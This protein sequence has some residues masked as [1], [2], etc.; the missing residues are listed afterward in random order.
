MNLNNLIKSYV[1]YTFS[2][3]GISLTIKASIGVSSF[4]SMNLAI[5]NAYDI[6]IGSVTIVFNMI[7]LAGYMF[8]TKFKN[9]QKYIIQ[10][11]SVLFFGILINSF[12]YTLLAN[13]HPSNYL[14][15]IFIMSIGT[16]ISGLSVGMI[17]NYDQ[18]TFPL[19]SLCIEISKISSIAF[20]KLRYFVDIIS[21]LVSISLSLIYKMPI[22]VREGTLI[23]MF[24]LSY[25]MNLP[26]AIASKKIAA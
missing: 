10:A 14:Q 13:F 23:S 7:F 17:I 12:T 15:S 6:K 1:F 24:L 16:I 26:K 22:F 11:I 8:M 5:A 21:V 4:N 2:A 20:I 3:F 25:A 9:K 19:E 18:I